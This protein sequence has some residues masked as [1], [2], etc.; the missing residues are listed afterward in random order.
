M[1]K[2]LLIAA[3][4]AFFTASLLE[5]SLSERLLWST[6]V[7]TVVKATLEELVFRGLALR[8]LL[9]RVSVN[10][11]VWVT[12]AVFAVAHLNVVAMPIYLAYGVAFGYLAI[13]SGSWVWTAF[14]HAGVNLLIRSRDVHDDFDTT[15]GLGINILLGIITLTVLVFAAWATFAHRSGRGTRD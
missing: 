10:A 11:A 15:F 13:L 9:K 2:A 8:Y 1:T 6:I 3:S 12:G 14:L 5:V 4:V 7:T